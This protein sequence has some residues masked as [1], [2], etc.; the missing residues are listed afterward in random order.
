MKGDVDYP[1]ELQ[2]DRAQGGW[3]SRHPDLSGCSAEGETADEAVANLATSR[4]L[5]IKAMVDGGHP[6]PPPSDR[7]AAGAVPS[8]EID[9]W[10]FEFRGGAATGE[11]SDVWPVV[12]FSGGRFELETGGSAFVIVPPKVFDRL[13]AMWREHHGT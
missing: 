13:R 5:W 11:Q 2:F 1:I 6:I 7:L 8:E 10:T 12:R 9:G 3:F 4:A